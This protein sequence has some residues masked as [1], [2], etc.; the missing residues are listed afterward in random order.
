L[1]TDG[2]AGERVDVEQAQR[3]EESLLLQRAW[4]IGVADCY[5]QF[6]RVAAHTAL[7]VLLTLPRRRCIAAPIPRCDAPGPAGLHRT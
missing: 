1:E 6:H 2:A 5:L 4:G 3:I 7:R